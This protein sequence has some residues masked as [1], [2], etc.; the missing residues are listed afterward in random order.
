MATMEN[1]CGVTGDLS[2]LVPESISYAFPEYWRFWLTGAKGVLTGGWNDKALTLYRNGEAKA[3]SVDAAPGTP[4]GYLDSFLKALDGTAG[5]E[6]LSAR[7]VMEATRLG[8]LF[9]EAAG[10]GRRGV[11]LPVTS[12]G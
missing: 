2:Y 1:G 4:G 10:R 3:I 9:Q 11:S 6:D 5:P 12:R 7:D 8:L